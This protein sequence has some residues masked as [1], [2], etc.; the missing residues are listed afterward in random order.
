MQRCL[1]GGNLR[2]RSVCTTFS[3]I[4]RGLLSASSALS[5]KVSGGLQ[6]TRSP[7][8]ALTTEDSEV[9]SVVGGGNGFPLSSP[10]S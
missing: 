9:S 10:F 2:T 4:V 7:T 1:T 8:C 5:C 3:G 6:R